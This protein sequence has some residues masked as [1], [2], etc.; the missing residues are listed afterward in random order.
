MAIIRNNVLVIVICSFHSHRQLSFIIH[1]KVYFVIFVFFFHNFW[2]ITTIIFPGRLYL[3]FVN[4]MGI[5]GRV[6]IRILDIEPLKEPM[7]I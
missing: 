6:F 5:L 4:S 3:F 2:D 1:D 7:E